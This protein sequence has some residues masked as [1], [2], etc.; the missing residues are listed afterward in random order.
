MKLNPN[1]NQTSDMNLDRDLTQA[2]EMTSV[3]AAV[4]TRERILI[5]QDPNWQDGETAAWIMARI[6]KSLPFRLKERPGSMPPDLT[7]KDQEVLVTGSR[8]V[9]FL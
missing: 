4:R 5:E 6:A 1:L 2:S 3:L 7:G 8:Q 9:Y